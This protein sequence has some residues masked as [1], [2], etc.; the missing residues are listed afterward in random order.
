MK[1]FVLALLFITTYNIGFSQSK[2]VTP[3]STA[4][5]P[6]DKE[7]QEILKGVSA[8]Y[9]TYKSV[10]ATFTVTME[11]PADK[12]KE[13]QKGTL[14]L[15]GEKYKLNVAGQDVISDGKT[16]WTY[17]KDGNEVQVNN[18][19]TDESAITPSNIFT[20]YEKGFMSKF[21][22][23]A[24]KGGTSFQDVELVPTDSK[25]KSYFKI[26]LTI[27]KMDKFITSAKVFNKNG[28][29]NTIAVDKFTPD[30]VTDETIFTFNSASYPGAEVIDLR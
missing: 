25:K 30:G 15:K 1:S 9:K 5:Q 23:E 17:V 4:V 22:G 10:K 24:T 29:I 27:N 11:N 7:A 19:K 16:V 14:Y 6:V 8:K 2:P 18:V 28:S 12:S 20:I 26:K 13:I 21:T 3:A